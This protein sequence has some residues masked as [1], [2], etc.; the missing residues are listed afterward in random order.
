MSRKIFVAVL[1]FLF[2]LAGNGWALAA[3]QDQSRKTVDEV[4]E[5]IL[6]YHKDNPKVQQLVEGAI[7]GMID[8]LEDPYT[9]YLAED[10]VDQFV[11][12]VNG[13]YQGVGIYMETQSDYPRVLE[14]FPDSP[15]SEGGV[16]P[17]DI[18]TGVDG[19][20]IKGLSLNEIVGFIKGNEGTSVELTIARDGQEIVLKLKRAALTVS[21]VSSRVMGN[22]TGYIAVKT[23]GSNTAGEFK[24]ALDGLAEQNITGLVVDLRDNP[25][26][27]LNA[28]AEMAEL[29]L[30]PGDLIVRTIYNDGTGEDYVTEK[31]DDKVQFPVVLLV[32]Q[33]SASA[34][35]VFAGALQDHGAAKLVGDNTFGKGV[36][37]KVIPLEQGGALK[38][39]MAEYTTPSGRHLNNI[40][41]KPD[42]T[43][44]TA[45]LQ[46]PF[47]LH[48]LQPGQPR[49]VRISPGSKEALVDGE[50]ISLKNEALVREGTVYFPLRFIF[51]ALGCE[52]L[53]DA[54]SGSITVKKEGK[55]ILIPDRGQPTLNG[56]KIESA[57]NLLVENDISYVPAE[58][59]RALGFSC[60]FEGQE[61]VVEVK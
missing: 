20:N 4:F 33:F 42:Y 16:L 26:G 36:V 39:T 19:K 34:S 60:T 31:N 57:G 9:V 6:K 51:E 32:N 17:G 45:E 23:F 49:L 3:D 13:N 41:I 59:L 12:A 53:W 56:N 8:T 44:T 10:E 38:L 54:G 29:F 48:V 7:W 35:E 14:V 2:T 1:I 55:S 24:K 21:S 58:M 22:S 18:I 43:V 15:A 28:A 30:K 11:D 5:Y 40:G 61:A 25:G 37:Q 50:K 27:F 46:L 47:A 52:V